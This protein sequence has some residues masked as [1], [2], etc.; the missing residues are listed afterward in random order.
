MDSLLRKIWKYTQIYDQLLTALR[1]KRQYV[2]QLK[3][4]EATKYKKGGQII[5]QAKSKK[6]G[7]NRIKNEWMKQNRTE[8]MVSLDGSVDDSDN[9]RETGSVTL[10]SQTSLDIDEDDEFQQHSGVNHWAP[11]LCR[12][13]SRTTARVQK[14]PGRWNSSNMFSVRKTIADFD[15]SM[16]DDR[17]S[18][19]GYKACFESLPQIQASH[20]ESLRPFLVISM[21]R[22]AQA[23]EHIHTVREMLETFWSNPNTPIAISSVYKLLG[24]YMLDRSKDKD[25][26]KVIIK[27]VFDDTII[28]RRELTWSHRALGIIPYPF[29]KHG[30]RRYNEDKAPQ[31][32]LD[33]EVIMAQFLKEL[34]PEFEAGQGDNL[35][36]V[37]RDC[38][39]W[40]IGVLEGRPEIPRVWQDIPCNGDDLVDW[41]NDYEVFC[42]LWNQWQTDTLSGLPQPSW[43]QRAEE[44]LCIS[45]TE[46]LITISYLIMDGDGDDE[47][48]NSNGAAAT[49]EHDP[50]RLVQRALKNAKLEAGSDD[51]RLWSNF[52]DKFCWMNELT[53]ME[54]KDKTFK[55][56]VMEYVRKYVFKMLTS[57]I[58]NVDGDGSYS[59][60]GP[61]KSFFSDHYQVFSRAGHSIHDSGEFLSTMTSQHRL[62]EMQLNLCN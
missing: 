12:G 60:S 54:Y 35:V 37:V 29:L 39:L 44:D 1:S 3:K 25:G 56:E 21:A 24:A 28:D 57:G 55:A 5:P 42:Y 58:H 15:F 4:W 10:S 2:H 43:V 49:Q 61:E 6:P 38:L 7:R 20:I 27:D 11:P 36:A 16:S 30:I 17:A 13:D 33:K 53:D 8:S 22:S 51:T 40:C 18:F 34:E 31:D 32:R 46:L 47:E 45:A 14:Q 48:G 52:L 41:K 19:E 62:N 50:Y 59:V 23:P 9:E 26:A